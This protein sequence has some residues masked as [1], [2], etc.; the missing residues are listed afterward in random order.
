MK[1]LPELPVDRIIKIIELKDIIVVRYRNPIYKKPVYRLYDL[2]A[3]CIEYD[4]C[5]FGDVL[6]FI[7]K[8]R[9]SK[10]LKIT[11]YQ[12]YYMIID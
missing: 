6:R 3:K 5:Y 8:Y 7:R 2:K 12:G 1:R 4:I 11:K 9:N 10:H